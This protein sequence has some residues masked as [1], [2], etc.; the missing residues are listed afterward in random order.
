M[1]RTLILD[2]HPAWPG[3]RI[4]AHVCYFAETAVY[5]DISKLFCGKGLRYSAFQ[6]DQ[7]DLD[8]CF[9]MLCSLDVA[10]RNDMAV[11][12][13]HLN[14]LKPAMFGLLQKGE[15]RSLLGTAT[16]L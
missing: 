1:K 2:W 6:H 7:L 10:N 11:A 3:Q 13:E 8:A 4:C 16:L 9:P 12:I 15:R 14:A 5:R